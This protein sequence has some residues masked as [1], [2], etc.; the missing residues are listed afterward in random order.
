MQ[1]TKP[2]TEIIQQRISVRTYA[3]SQIEP[4]KETLLKECLFSNSTGPFQTNMRF[5]LITARPGDTEALK[6][7]RTY[8]TIKNPAGFIVGITED[9]AGQKAEDFGYVMETIILH[10]TDLDL[11]TCWLGGTFKKSSFATAAGVKEHETVPAVTSVG[12]L[13]EKIGL[14]D[15][16]IRYTIG[17]KKRLPWEQLFFSEKF[18][19]PLSQEN[20]GVYSVPLEMIRLGPSASNKQPWRIVKELDRNTFHFYLQRNKRYSRQLKWMKLAD[21][22]LMDIGI[23]MCH[24]ELTAH[25]QGLSG[26][27]EL[28]E[29]GISPLPE[30]TEY[31]VSWKGE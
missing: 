10:A 22:Q 20:A 31:V 12:N 15:S 3:K 5:Q 11:G 19:T 26:K 9:S 18:E 2:I 7:L 25:E 30:H 16:F 23:A 21:L 1:F 28:T 14:R 8:G 4:R 17:A 24:F 27:W 6:G 13:P 29:P